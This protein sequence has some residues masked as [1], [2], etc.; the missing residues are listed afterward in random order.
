MAYFSKLRELL[1]AKGWRMMPRH[2][3]GRSSPFMLESLEARV[4]LSADLAAAIPVADIV[5]SST[6]G[7]QPAA[8]VSSQGVPATAEVSWSVA[9]ILKSPVPSQAVS[10]K[11]EV[12]WGRIGSFFTPPAQH[13]GDFGGY[14]SVLDL[15][16]G[17]RITTADQWN[18]R[19]VEIRDY[20]LQQIGPWPAPIQ[21]PQ[22]WS[23]MEQP[24]VLKGLPATIS[25]WKPFRVPRLGPSCSRRLE[26]AHSPPRSIFGIFRRKA[27][28]L[29][30]PV[31]AMSIL[32]IN[33][34]SGAS[35]RSR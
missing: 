18:Q 29:H 26:M 3:A 7:M 2:G 21:H 34:R 24:S 13:A 5:G 25:S 35:S 10:S 17:S 9:D 6:F 11:G 30:R 8:T 19:R 31:L 27:P 16:D 12:L 23:T 33:S 14:G 32:P 1:S 22:S 4:L 20:W 15:P 28:A